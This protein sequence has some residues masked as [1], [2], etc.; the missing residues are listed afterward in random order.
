L[1]LSLN[2]IAAKAAAVARISQAVSHILIQ[3]S[4]ITMSNFIAK[5]DCLMCIG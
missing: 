5:F 3:L 2:K 4:N 1:Q